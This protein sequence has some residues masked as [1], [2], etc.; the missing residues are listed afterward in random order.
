MKGRTAWP[1]RMCEVVKSR[2]PIIIASVESKAKL[3]CPLMRHIGFENTHWRIWTCVNFRKNFLAKVFREIN[4]LYSRELPA[5][6]L[7]WRHFSYSGP[8]PLILVSNM[9][10]S[11]SLHERFVCVARASC[12]NLESVC[13][14][15]TCF[16]EAL[17]V[18]LIRF[19]YQ[20]TQL[21]LVH[22]NAK[23]GQKWC[24]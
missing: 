4:N 21:A 19:C 7:A 11:T 6:F 1:W 8:L 10:G 12:L 16:T 18:S 22:C 9:A 17:V 13:S 23:I 24:L 20:P 3:W 14:Y 5:D 2:S 15:V